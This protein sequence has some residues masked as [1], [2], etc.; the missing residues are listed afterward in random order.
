MDFPAVTAKKCFLIKKSKKLLKKV[1]ENEDDDVKLSRTDLHGHGYHVV[2]ADFTDPKALETKLAECSVDFACPTVF[3]AE[4]VLVYVS[5]AKT[6]AFLSWALSKFASPSA[7]GSSTPIPTP[8]AFLNHEQ[9]HMNDR[10][11]AV[12]LDNLSARGCGLPG[13]SACVDKQTQIRRFLGAKSMLVSQQ[14]DSD[15]EASTSSALKEEG[16]VASSWHRWDS[17]LCWTM[18]EIY[19]ELLPRDEVARVESLEMFDEKEL[20]RQLFDH[21]CL[22]IAWRNGRDIL[23]DDIEFW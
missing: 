13:V 12:M 11:G 20:M 3:L 2:G 16:T 6:D 1:V 19:N 17:A 10:F 18:S 8:L 23:F 4:C 21:Y 22:T 14:S 7:T 9:I 5:P 15:S